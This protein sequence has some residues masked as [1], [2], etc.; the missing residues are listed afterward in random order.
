MK[1]LIKKVNALVVRLKRIFLIRFT[2]DV[3]ASFGKNNGGLMAAGLAFFLVLAFVPLLLVG[4]AAIGYYFNLIHS[5]QDAVQQIQHLLTTQILPG[6]AGNEVSSLMEQANITEKVKTIT[7]TRGIS[8]IIGLLGLIWAS[9]QIFLSGAMAMNAAW[10]VQETRNW[11]QQRAIALGLLLATGVLLVLSIVATAYG[12]WLTH[13]VPGFGVGTTILTE[14][15]AVIVATGMYGMTYKFLP[16][17]H[18]TWRSALVGGVVAAVAWEIAKKGL[19]VYLLHPNT[20]MYGNLANLMIFVLW[21]YYSMMILLIGCE[22]SAQY[23]KEVESKKA[24][25]MKRLANRTPSLDTSSASGTPMARA[26][27][28]RVSQRERAGTKTAPSERSAAGAPAASPE[29][30]GSGANGRGKPKARD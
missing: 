8:G 26:K 28:R 18:V 22:V 3:I 10:S 11:F 14:V 1:S 16:S 15:G 12:S 30:N 2:M 7:V 20:S 13:H 25:K 4:V 5:T 23:A 24:T 27:E 21:V 9:M 6:K 17:A 19:A 29:R